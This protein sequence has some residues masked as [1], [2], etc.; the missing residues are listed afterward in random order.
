MNKKM[1]IFF[2]L[3]FP[4][5][6]MP[7]GQTVLVPSHSDLLSTSTKVRPFLFS[8]LVMGVDAKLQASTFKNVGLSI[9]LLQRDHISWSQSRE[10]LCYCVYYLYCGSS[11]EPQ[12]RIRTPLCQVLY[13]TD[14]KNSP[15]PKDLTICKCPVTTD[16]GVINAK[17]AVRWTHLLSPVTRS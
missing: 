9:Y 2:Q 1:K 12:S 10:I 4:G 6:T 13:N 8:Y 14:Q 7:N 11:L 17:P 5:K 15:C 16:T 3:F